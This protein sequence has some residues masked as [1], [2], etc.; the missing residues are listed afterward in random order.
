MISTDWLWVDRPRNPTE[1]VDRG[2]VHEVADSGD[3]WGERCLEGKMSIIQVSGVTRQITN[4]Y[5]IQNFH[6]SKTLYATA[7]VFLSIASGA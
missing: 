5:R 6:F 7:I 4:P 1:L 3:E 2:R